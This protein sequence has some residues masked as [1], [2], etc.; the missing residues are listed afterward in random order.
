V[1]YLVERHLRLPD[2]TFPHLGTTNDGSVAEVVL[3][4]GSPDRVELM[5]SMLEGVERVG[6]RRGYTVYTGLYQ[7]RR[8]TVATSGVGAPSASIAIEELGA[9]GG[10]VF[11]RVGS[12]ASIAESV[13]IGNVV[14]AHAA[15]SDEGTSR[16]YAPVN[17]PPVAAPR[18]VAALLDAARRLRVPVHV[19]LTRSTDSFYEGERK[20]EIIDTW[21]EV[22]VLTFEMETSALF[23]VAAVRGWEA[24]AIL[25][26]GSNL[27]TGEA[28][29]EG[30]RL[31]EYREGERRMLDVA[32]A[33]AATLASG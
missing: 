4:S 15:V 24:G 21:R 20:A 12:C 2:G 14:V 10:R 25:V 31:E 16:Y 18:V 8:I 30:N 6:D 28:T 19:G 9:C 17:F 22:G 13:A 3:L 33:A 32:L 29:Y 27:I 1:D 7:G 5:A 11:M 26:P 23:T